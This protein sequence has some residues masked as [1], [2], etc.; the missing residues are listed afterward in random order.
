[1]TT[2]LSILSKLWQVITMIICWLLSVIIFCLNK[3][4]ELLEQNDNNAANS[5]S[6]T[7]QELFSW[8][9][10]YFS[11]KDLEK[12]NADKDKD[13]EKRGYKINNNFDDLF[14]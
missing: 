10:E 13:T 2:F 14:I 6:I 12:S 7:R 8:L 4:K 3:L 5:G 11:K 1:M 9:D